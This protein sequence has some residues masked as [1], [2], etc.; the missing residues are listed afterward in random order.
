M[1]RLALGAGTI[2]RFINANLYG[3]YSSCDFF[4][5]H[6]GFF[7][8]KHVERNRRNAFLLR[9]GGRPRASRVDQNNGDVIPVSMCGACIFVDDAAAGYLTTL[10]AEDALSTYVNNEADCNTLSVDT[11]TQ[12][13]FNMYPNP[14]EDVLFITFENMEEDEIRVDVIDSNGKLLSQE[15]HYVG[16]SN[17]LQIDMSEFTDGLYFIRISNDRGSYIDKVVKQ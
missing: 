6:A 8:R 16:F 4:D 10:W 13:V 1:T 15:E 14:V 5:Q 9:H 12:N 2:R 3:I 7:R 11:E 17:Q